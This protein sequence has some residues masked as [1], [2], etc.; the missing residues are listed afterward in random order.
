MKGR[1][2]T[3]GEGGAVKTLG[4]ASVGPKRKSGRTAAPALVDVGGLGRGEASG[5]PARATPA[6]IES[7][8]GKGGILY[9]G[10]SGGKGLE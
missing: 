8:M 5:R 4:V 9:R 6:R 10:Q 1:V 7:Q 3:G 2:W